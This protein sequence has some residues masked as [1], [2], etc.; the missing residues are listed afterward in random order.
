M[1]NACMSCGSFG[2][3]A[4]CPIDPAWQQLSQHIPAFNPHE[5]EKGPSSRRARAGAA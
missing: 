4:C 1:S 3:C 2:G 5:A